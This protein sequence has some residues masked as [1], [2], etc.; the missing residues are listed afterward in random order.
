MNWINNL[1]VANKIRSLIVVIVLFMA[2]IAGTY[3]YYIEQL[4]ASIDDMY[5]Q[6]LL[7]VKYL[8]A[9]RWANPCNRG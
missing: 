9:L 8:N 4:S 5:Q 1:T 7:P 3:Y 2:C 6:E